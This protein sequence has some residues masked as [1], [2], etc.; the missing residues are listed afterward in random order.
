[1]LDRKGQVILYGPS[2]TGK[3]YWARI[4]A[5]ELAARE[6]FRKTRDQLDPKERVL[7]EGSEQGNGLVR[8]CT[9]HPAYGYEDF[10]EG[11][12]PTSTNGALGFERRDGIF[13]RLCKDAAQAPERTHYLLVDEVNRGDIPRIFGELLT[14]LEMDKRGM[15]LTLPASGEVFSVPPNV[16]VIGTMNTADRSIALLDTA[17]RRRFGFIELMPEY[18]LLRDVVFENLPIGDWLKVLNGE[19][20]KRLG[21]DGRNLQI[22]HAFFM[23][24]GSP[25]TDAGTFL[26]VLFEDVVPLLEE[27]FYDDPEGLAQLLGNTIMDPKEQ[28]VNRDLLAPGRRMDVFSSLAA[29]HPDLLTS[30]PALNAAEDE[31][32]GEEEDEPEGATAG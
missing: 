27:Y 20:R 24:N 13:K 1:V 32:E 2:G 14:L 23:Q 21:N 5:F 30:A 11:Y 25:I 9:F 17:L 22:G 19:V 3:T 29:L 4:A 12:R 26:K 16:R 7:I 28:R 10:L 8:A 15:T 6:V 31:V 18:E